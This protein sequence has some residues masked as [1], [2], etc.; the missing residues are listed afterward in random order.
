MTPVAGPPRDLI[1][2]EGSP[3]IVAWPGGARIAISLVVNYEE[4]SEL[5]IGDGD[6][7]REPSGPEDWPLTKRDLAGESQYEYGS[8]AGYWRL[9]DI[10]DEQDVKCTFYACAVALERN[11]D[12]AREMRGR[13]HDVISHGWRWEDVSLLTREEE[14]DHIKRAVASITETTGERPLG[15]Y[16]RYG[17]SVNTRELVVEEGGFLYDC[18]AY[19][20]D[21]PYWTWVG[22]KKHLVIPYSLANNDG[23]FTFG[24]FGSPAD[25]ENYLKAN[26]DQLY[27]EGATHPKMMSVGLHMRIVGHP[28]PAQGLSNF[29]E[30]AKSF[31]D[32]WFARRIDIAKHWID[33]HG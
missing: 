24:A 20:D 32:V 1:G 5:A 33:H 12:A 22:D 17:P 25:F 19:N 7:T 27:K 16:C 15:W 14:R 31:P 8:R 9:L 2:Y 28:G 29:I 26:F 13:G 23:K 21:L 30:Y 11:R 3:P 6:A 4:G 10:F 18:D